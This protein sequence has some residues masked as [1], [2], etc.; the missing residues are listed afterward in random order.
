[1]LVRVEDAGNQLR[2]V[3]A[4]TGIGMDAEAMEK[5]FHRYY[6]ANPDREGSGLGLLIARELVR[7]HAGD[8]QVESELGRGST[9]TVTL[10]YSMPGTAVPT[11]VA[12]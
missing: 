5:I 11:A 6:R 4:D 8:I 1:V 3:I 7:L 9:F 12:S 2:V 10:P